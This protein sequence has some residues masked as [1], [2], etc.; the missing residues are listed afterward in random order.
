MYRSLAS[1]VSFL[2]TDIPYVVDRIISGEVDAVILD[3]AY[4]LVYS[5]GSPWYTQETVVSEDMVLRIAP[6][7]NFSV[8]TDFLDGLAKDYNARVQ[9]TGWAL[10]KHP[11]AITRMYQRA[12]YSLEDIPQLTKRRR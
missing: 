10:A 6:G 1:T 3:E 2:C 11:R 7:S 9:I 5:V 8:V 12:G 4:L